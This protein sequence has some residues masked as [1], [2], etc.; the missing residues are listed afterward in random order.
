MFPFLSAADEAKVFAGEAAKLFELVP[1]PRRKFVAPP[2]W[3]TLDPCGVDGVLRRHGQVARKAV[4]NSRDGWMPPKALATTKKRPATGCHDNRQ[5]KL[6]ALFRYF[7]QFGRSAEKC[8]NALENKPFLHST[9]RILS[10]A[11]LPFRHFGKP[12]PEKYILPPS[13]RRARAR[14]A[15]VNAAAKTAGIGS[16]P[17]RRAT[18]LA[19]TALRSAV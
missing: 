19:C 4:V 6:F 17:L 12:G 10:P 3:V 14:E 18:D 5:G 2:R 13:Q 16:E 9:G 8:Q 15:V 11:R 1:D 7:L